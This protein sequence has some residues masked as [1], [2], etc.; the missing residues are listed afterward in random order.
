MDEMVSIFVVAVNIGICML[1]GSL[2]SFRVRNDAVYLPLTIFFFLLAF[3]NFNTVMNHIAPQYDV[4]L[5][6]ISLTIVAL[7]IWPMFWFYIEG[8][9]HETRWKFR[10]GHV[11][12]LIPTLF[13]LFTAILIFTL[14]DATRLSVFDDDAQFAE[15]P[16]AITAMVSSSLILLIW[17][18]QTAIY[19]IMGIN[20]LIKYRQ[21]LK[22]IF[23]ST[24]NREL[25]WLLVLFLCLGLTGFFFFLDLF[26]PLVPEDESN[27]RSAS[28]E[29]FVLMAF[30]F[31]LS[32]WGL[33]QKP[34]FEQIY[35]IQ[36]EEEEKNSPTEESK[37][38]NLPAPTQG[39][40]SIK[41]QKSGLDDVR[42]TRIAGKLEKLM[43]TEELYHARQ[44]DWRIYK[45]SITD[46]K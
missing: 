13:G 43:Q 8:L 26:F 32:I 23:A 46:V 1:A 24:E 41:Y 44:E 11:K 12:H 6:T 42:A 4:F 31:T 21:R 34:G 3:L 19:F 17:G 33:R 16:L 27:V 39:D 9:T 14:P 45:Y 30:L 36:E 7:L 28:L 40:L 2:L 18:L 25:T 15:T 22:D 5:S 20:R 38:S 10:H 29:E 37:A 35:E